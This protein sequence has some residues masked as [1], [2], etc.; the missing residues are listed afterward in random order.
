MIKIPIK[1]RAQWLFWGFA[2]AF[3]YRVSD[4][5]KWQSINNAVAEVVAAKWITHTL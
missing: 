2:S 1:Y 3:G 4:E 5:I